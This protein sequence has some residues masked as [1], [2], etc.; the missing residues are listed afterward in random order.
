MFAKEL[1]KECHNLLHY[2]KL[3]K[4]AEANE[5]KVDEKKLMFMNILN[6]N[7]LMTNDDKNGIIVTRC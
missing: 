3:N 5:I 6:A 2:L 4:D 7:I 1:P